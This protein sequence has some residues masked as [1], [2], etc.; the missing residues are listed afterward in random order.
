MQPH[1]NRPGSLFAAA[2]LACA[3][4][5]GPSYAEEDTAV[6]VP[7]IGLDRLLRLPESLEVRGAIDRRGGATEAEWRA[8]F[9]AAKADQVAADEALAEARVELGELAADTSAWQVSAP[10]MPNTGNADVPM[11]YALSQKLKRRRED[12]ERA[13]RR[14]RELGVEADLAGV[15]ES[16]ERED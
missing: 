5:G 3:L 14:L 9:A 13:E 7:Q 11:D 10:G 12:V 15:P 6:P 8:R 2:A 4:G 16:W 1:G